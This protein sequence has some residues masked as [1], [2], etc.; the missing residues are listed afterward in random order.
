M[1]AAVG[2]YDNDGYED[3][4]VTQ[5]GRNILYHNNGDGTFTDVTAH[6]GLAGA[7]WSTSATWVDYDN[8]GKL[9]LIVARYLTWDFAEIWCGERK[10]GHRA[11]CHP[12]LFKPITF[13]LYHNDDGKRFR[14]VSQQAGLTMPGKGLGVAIA[15]YDDDR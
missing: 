7:G 11:Y 13:L 6:A 2:D 9:D 15:D 1:G 12:N 4:F 5:Y 8:D 14:E 10:E 3:L